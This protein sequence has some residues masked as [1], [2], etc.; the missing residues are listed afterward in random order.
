MQDDWILNLNV[1]SFLQDGCC[2]THNIYRCVSVQ[3]KQSRK[4]LR[5]EACVNPNPWMYKNCKDLEI[6]NLPSY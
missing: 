4:N 2:Q 3:Q 6:I 5:W 1:R